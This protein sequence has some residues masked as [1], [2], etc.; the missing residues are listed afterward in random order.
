MDGSEVTI[1]VMRDL[2]RD[3]RISARSIPEIIGAMERALSRYGES[4]RVKFR[5]RKLSN[6]AFI[7][8]ALLHVLELPAEEQERVLGAAIKRLEAILKGTAAE[9][10]P[11]ETAT[12]HPKRGSNRT[13]SR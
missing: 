3:Q 12:K 2:D 8:A 4:R 9:A 13:G 10:F 11:F 5:S 6:E 1:Q 7:N